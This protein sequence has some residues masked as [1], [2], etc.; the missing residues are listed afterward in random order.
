MVGSET[1]AS[2]QF[3]TITFKRQTAATNL[4][5]RVDVSTD[6]LTWAPASSYSAMGGT[7]SGS[8]QEIMNVPGTFQTI[9]LRDTTAQ[10]GEPKRFYRVTESP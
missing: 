1:I 2:S 9:T 10:N 6:L 4:T 3:A 8:L 5:Q 7:Q